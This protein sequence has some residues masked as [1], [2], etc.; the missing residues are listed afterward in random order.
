MDAAPLGL[1]HCP[2][3]ESV[4]DMAPV[5][6]NGSVP[7]QSLPVMDA[8]CFVV[9]NG[10]NLGD[11]LSFACDMMLDDIYS[12]V[13]DAPRHRLAL[14]AITDATYFVINDT[15]EIGSPG[16]R[17]HLDCCATFMSPD[18]ST[19]EVIVMVE[20]SVVDDAVEAVYFLPL[21]RLTPKQ[22]YSLV[23][24]DTEAARAICRGGLCQLY[25]RH[26][27]HA[28]GRAAMPN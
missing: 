3:T 10:A 21:A 11:G 13:T 17:V 23:G 5:S 24:I 9:T 7:V 25:P 8:A 12:L 16:S 28:G 4:Q 2:N 14:S 18:G 15:T 26:Q 19:V 1:L 20:V 22:E 6:S 27:H